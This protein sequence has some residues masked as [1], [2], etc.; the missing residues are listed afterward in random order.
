VSVLEHPSW[1]VGAAGGCPGPWHQSAELAVPGNDLSGIEARTLLWQGKGGRQFVQLTLVPVRDNA[2]AFSLACTL[3]ESIRMSW[4]DGGLSGTDDATPSAVPL[5]DLSDPDDDDPE[6]HD[7]TIDQA[8]VL[9][10]ALGE[11]L[12]NAHRSQ[13]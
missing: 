9:H 10:R 11:L 13:V 6:V 1:C 4:N 5:E 7:F 8:E 3:S 12:A 2:V